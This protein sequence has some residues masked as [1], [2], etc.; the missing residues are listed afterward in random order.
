VRIDIRRLHRCLRGRASQTSCPISQLIT[1]RP[2]AVFIF[3]N[4]GRR[5]GL[6]PDAGYAAVAPKAREVI[7]SDPYS[8]ICFAM[9]LTVPARGLANGLQSRSMAYNDGPHRR[10]NVISPEQSI[11]SSVQARQPSGSLLTRRQRGIGTTAHQRSCRLCPKWLLLR[12]ASGPGLQQS[13][14]PELV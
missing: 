9:R 11:R 8:H 3:K 4:S 14:V 5:P 1:A 12:A 13:C 10:A 6:S 7:T 2:F